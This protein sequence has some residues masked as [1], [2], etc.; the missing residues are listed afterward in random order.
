M[1]VSITVPGSKSIANRA[2]L[3]KA[4][5]KSN[6]EIL[7]L[8]DCDDVK[9][10]LK[11]LE[12]LQQNKQN[13]KLY[14]GNA[15]TTTRFLTAYCTLLEKNISINGD[16]RMQERP[17]KELTDALNKL[18]A[19][20]KTKNGCPPLEIHQEK[21]KGGN[22]KLKGNIS[23]QYLS[24][25]LMCLPF[26]PQKS[27]IKIEQ[28]LC[29]Q[30]YVNITINLLKQFGIQI[31]NNKFAQFS[32]EPQKSKAPKKLTV[33]ADASS[34]SYIGAYAALNPQKQITLKNINSKSIQGD[35][36]FLQ[37]LKKMGCEIKEIKNDTMIRGPKS[38]KAL[39]LIDMNAT[40][41]LVMT[42]AVLAAFA[43]GKSKII[44][45]SN[46]R[47]KETDRLEALKNELGKIGTKV[48]TG[49]DYIEIIGEENFKPQKA[50]VK[51]YD[52]HRIAMAFGIIK[53]KGELTI[54][55]PKCVVKSYPTFWQDLKKLQNAL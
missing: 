12:I 44:N 7:N 46:L 11:N 16:K 34:A 4:L 32:I 24:A 54:E 41:D 39:G 50:K 45:I 14:T 20:I 26:C 15:G 10:M 49:K 1:S 35:I 30:P 19:N 48:K 47:I 55:N 33:E 13:H 31:K 8:P 43:K 6:T 5:S 23:S 52:D 22:I 2:L 17:I 27:A 9:Y 36:K 53:N 28:K 3:L 18:G 29:S 51:T 21:L 38:L 42:F 25:L 37:Y 40:P